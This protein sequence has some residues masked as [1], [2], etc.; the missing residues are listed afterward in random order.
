MRSTC[1]WLR[2]LAL[3]FGTDVFY[4]NRWLK[5]R[6]IRGSIFSRFDAIGVIAELTAIYIKNVSLIFFCNFRLSRGLLW[7]ALQS[8][9]PLWRHAFLS[10]V[11]WLYTWVKLLL[12]LNKNIT[13]D[14]YD[15]VTLYS[16]QGNLITSIMVPIKCLLEKAFEILIVIYFLMEMGSK[17]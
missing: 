3:I 17:S 4:L 10:S 11:I 14:I 16:W 6:R 1:R 15:T 5:I 2:N 9:L 13:Y 7:E 8:I 12:L